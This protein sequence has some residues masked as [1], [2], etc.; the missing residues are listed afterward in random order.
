MAGRRGGGD[1]EDFRKHA[2]GAGL[3]EGMVWHTCMPPIY[4]N[5]SVCL[6]ACL[7][8]KKEMS[9]TIAMNAFPYQASAFHRPHQLVGETKLVRVGQASQTHREARADVAHP[10]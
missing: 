5:L 9:A 3:I 10:S 6:P 4:A 1:A 8:F 2:W 7:A